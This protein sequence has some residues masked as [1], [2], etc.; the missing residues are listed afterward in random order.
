MSIIDLIKREVASGL[1]VLVRDLRGQSSEGTEEPTVLRIG[2]KIEFEMTARNDGPFPLHKL[3]FKVFQMRAV[4][5]EAS[6]VECRIELLLPGE[7]KRLTTI[8]G[9]VVENPDDVQSPWR[10]SDSLCRTTITGEIDVPRLQ[11]QD[12]EFE[13]VNVLD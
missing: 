13:T 7:E 3:E 11:F 5:F 12:E 8:R 10:V 2:D 1:V 6:P 9:T 4:E